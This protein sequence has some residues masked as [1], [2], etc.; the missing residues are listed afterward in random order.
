[1]TRKK[2]IYERFQNY[3]TLNKF[4]LDGADKFTKENGVDA[5]V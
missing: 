3:Q 1:M 2:V 5:S 4:G